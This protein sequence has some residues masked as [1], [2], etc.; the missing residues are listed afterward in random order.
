M[1]AAGSGR[2]RHLATPVALATAGAKRAAFRAA[3]CAPSRT[4]WSASS[5]TEALCMHARARH[6]PVSL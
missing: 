1:R 3:S 2:R 5:H 4:R 6:R